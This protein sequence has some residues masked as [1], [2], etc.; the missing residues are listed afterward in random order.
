MRNVTGVIQ[1]APVP[2][3]K[4][5]AIL[6]QQRRE[7]NRFSICHAPP[8]PRPAGDPS[9]KSLDRNHAIGYEIDH[10]MQPRPPQAA[11]PAPPQG[12]LCGPAET[13]SPGP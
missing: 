13:T 4:N 6:A 11:I 9:S 8:V 1:N 7:G 5:G 3:R 2:P 10:C 12:S